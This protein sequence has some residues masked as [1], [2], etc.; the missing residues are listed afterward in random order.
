[1]GKKSKILYYSVL[2]VNI[3]CFILDL[4]PINFPFFRV[5]FAVSL[6]LI[7]ILLIVRGF[8][9]KLDSSLFFG[10]VLFICG[11]LNFVLYF[12]QIYQSIDINQFWPYYLFAVAIASFIA[13]V[14]FKDKLQMK[15]FILFLGFGLISLV[16]VQNLINIW[17]MIGLMIAWFIGYFVVNLILAK[18]R[19]N[20]GQKR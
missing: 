16:F 8:S 10:I 12:L 20:N 15:L 17:W 5:S 4:L 2:I 3:V 18:R 7:G 14:Y 1:M 9:L 6:I 11:V 19:K 13:S